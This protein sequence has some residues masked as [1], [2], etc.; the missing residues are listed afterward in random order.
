MTSANG[1]TELTALTPASSQSAA[2]L[3]ILWLK[4]ELL[5]PVDK[6]GRVRT[7]QMLRALARDHHVTYLTL[8]DGQS[9][10]DA[11]ERSSEYAAVTL[12]VPFATARKRTARFYTELAM[13]CFSHLPY[14]IAKYRSPAMMRTIRDVV[15]AGEIDIVVCDFLASAVNVPDELPCPVVLFQHNVEATIWERHA[16]TAGGVFKRA[17]FREQWRRMREFEAR[18]CRRFDHL[19]AVSHEDAERIRR[20]YGAPRVTEIATG[21]DVE[22]F[23]PSGQPR[24]SRQEL[25]FTGSMDWL[26]NE[27]A[28]IYFVDQILPRV[29]EHVPKASFTIVGRNPSR[30]VLALASVP[31]VEVTGSVEDVRPYVERADVFLVPLRIGGGTRLKIFEAMAMEKPIVSTTIGAEGLPVRD[32]DTIVIADRPEDFARAVV[33][34]L[35]DHH[36]RSALGARAAADVRAHYAWDRVAAHFAAVCQQVIA[37][38]RSRAR[39]AQLSL[40]RHG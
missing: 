37:R 9:A 16:R 18:Q 4:T 10:A 23:R 32:G 34:L 38:S 29:R 33:R 7:Y 22:Y 13:N 1:R 3:R 27:D 6:G 28:V 21:V 26:P 35:D 19:V 11:V 20:D 2:G 40:S 31:G 24:R 36:T 39:S 14:A 15:T 5:H 30:R 8:D 12:R 25:T 17:Y